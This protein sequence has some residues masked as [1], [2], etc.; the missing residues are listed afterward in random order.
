LTAAW[1]RLRTAFH[2]RQWQRDLEDELQFHLE[3][4]Q[5]RCQSQ[6]FSA[7]DAG[8]AARRQFGNL[9]LVKEACR[10]MWTL[11]WIET[12]W[13]DVRYGCRQLRLNRS[14]A[15][16]TATTLALGIA[17]T[18]TI[19]SVCDAL[20]W[21][22][23]PLPD[24]DTLIT[25]LGAFPGNPH[26]WSPASPAGVEDIRKSQTMLASLASWEN[27]TANIV[28]AG[29]EPLRVDQ[30]RVTPNFFDVLG[31]SPELGRSFE[32]G[33]DQPGRDREVVL[34]DGLWRNR[35]QADR[36]IVGKTIRLND[37][38]YTVVGVMPPRFAF[39]RASK[40]LWT[41]L[42]FA[43]EERN[44][45]STPRV[46]SA[47]RMKPG[48]TLRQAAL[49]LNRLGLQLE[50]LYPQTNTNRRFMAWPVRRY[51]AG[52]YAA[53]FANLLLGAALF[54]LL[55]AC[56]NA[57]NLQF[58]RGTA[59]W[60]EV[61][62]RQALGA[63]RWQI[64][65]QLVTES[66]VLALAGAGLGVVL[67]RYGLRAIRAGIPPE[68]QKYSS[69]WADLGLNAGV[70]AFVLAAAVLSGILAGLVPALRS[71]HANLAES[72][73][74]GGHASS[75]GPGRHRARS[76]L[77]AAEIALTMVL[78]VGAGLMIRGFH[79]LVRGETAIEPRTLLTLRLEL[80]ATE[81]RTPE[82]VAEFYRLV[83]DRTAALPGVQAATAASALP[84][85]R[86]ARFSAFTISGRAAQ[87]GRQP[88]AQ[89]QVV[90]ADYL[91][92]MHIPLRAGRFLSDRDGPRFPLSAVISEEIA[93]QW[94][95]GEP[96]PIGRQIRLGMHGT[97]GPVITIV[98]VVG[99]V[100]ASAL[101]RVP[102]PALYVP[103][104]QFPEQGMDI[105]IRSA[106]DPLSL[107][108]PVRLAIKAVDAEQPVT[109]M[110][111][112]E[113]MKQNEVIGLTYTAVLMSIFG[114]IALVLSCVGVY[115]MMS[116][117]VSRQTHEIGVRMALGAGRWN[118]L[119]MLFRQGSRA[120]L[121]GVTSGL[122]L[123]FAFARL[124]ASVIWGVSGTDGGTFT[125]I[126]LVLVLAAGLAIY[127]PA[128][129]ALRIDLLIAL[130]SE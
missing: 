95:P 102:R 12:L 106:G 125:A 122:L 101:D 93:R 29:G 64:V 80:D 118:V 91:R 34:S 15:V 3:M 75:S 40:D 7:G 100:K 124:L 114:A 42:A 84:Y 105:A 103:Y 60:R 14:F 22:T 2:R 68:L 117:L 90:S 58:A 128:R 16:V 62:V 39:P 52:D 11:G 8:Y 130:R 17:A 127:I 47:G 120:G 78:L 49:E 41:P 104:T 38:D 67:A 66:L 126:P 26:F 63:T 54:V 50:K 110:M 82:K 98:G 129:R 81:Y 73:K 65:T 23:L 32:P 89:L 76:V 55:I 83:L 57:A 72:L 56:G 5:E 36:G 116:Y 43:P 24:P 111:T 107:A 97:T 27:A 85:S 112:L 46:D 92:T 6:G 13:R 53:Q 109:D 119:G 69:G 35:F 61:A 21:K 70:L 86:H 121:A 20:V 59:R 37:Q 45:R 94:W 113:R 25:V 74:E 48:H 10:E 1:L 33:D 99:G 44:S 123:A 88:S 31:V 9:M 87:P 18:T 30:A 71:S 96:A 19:Y 77:L 115:G 51:V 28:D 108:A 79:N 4:R